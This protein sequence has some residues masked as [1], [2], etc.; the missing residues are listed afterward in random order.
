MPWTPSLDR[1]SIRLPD[2][3]YSSAGWYFVTINTWGWCHTLARVRG[4]RL[5]LTRMGEIVA[6]RWGEI[7]HHYPGVRIDAFV[8]MPNHVHGI[9]RIVKS[10]GDGV[11]PGPRVRP[12]SLSAVVRSF[13]AASTRAVHLEIA[14]YLPLWHRNYH[15]S[16]LD[17]AAAL[18]AVR[19]YIADNPA[20]WIA[21]RR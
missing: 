3:D 14:R 18:R 6:E 5:E 19:R 4:G 10:Q 21:T 7:P 20:R 1:R 12:G 11:P 15:E 16:I 9:V 13:K 2:W 8:V 17:D